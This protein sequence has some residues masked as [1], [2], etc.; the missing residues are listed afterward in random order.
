MLIY[1]VGP[2]T[3][4]AYA[5]LAYGK[6]KSTVDG[7]E[8]EKDAWHIMEHGTP[9]GPHFPTSGSVFLEPGEGGVVRMLWRDEKSDSL[10]VLTTRDGGKNFSAEESS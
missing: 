8:V 4:P 7:K 1:G 10:H 2:G 5:I 9:G 3:K 6:V